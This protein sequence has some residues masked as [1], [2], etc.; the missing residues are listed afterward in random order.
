[1][2]FLN[3][4]AKNFDISGLSFYCIFGTYVNGAYV[5]IPGWGISCDLSAYGNDEL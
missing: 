2:G 1:M 5:A 4:S 3:S